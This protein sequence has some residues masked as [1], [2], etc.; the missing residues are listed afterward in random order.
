VQVAELPDGIAAHDIQSIPRKPMV[1]LQPT[2][3]YGNLWIAQPVNEKARLVFESPTSIPKHPGECG[4]S[5][6]CS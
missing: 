5:G 4:V 2:D 1:I 6:S 3:F